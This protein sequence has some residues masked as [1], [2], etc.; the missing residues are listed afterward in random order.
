MHVHIHMHILI[1][2]CKYNIYLNMHVLF[3]VYMARHAE[4]SGQELKYRPTA[5]R[6][7]NEL[8]C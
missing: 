5:I 4:R 7:S 1:Y 3:C 8:S 2:I 6:I